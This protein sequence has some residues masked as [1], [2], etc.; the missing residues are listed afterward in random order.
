MNV[1]ELAT[2]GKRV[3][4]LRVARDITQVVLAGK[5]TVSQPS[6]SGIERDEFI[7][8]K[9]IRNRIAETLGVHPDFIWRP[10]DLARRVRATGPSV[11]EN[12]ST[13]DVV[14]GRRSNGGEPARD[15]GQ[16]ADHGPTAPDASMTV[17]PPRPST[18]EAAA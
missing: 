16:A 15:A 7:P 17:G 3:R 5:A 13:P 11:A 10:E 6:I 14:A 4:W 18:A 9:V 8:R 1:E 12:A 2:P